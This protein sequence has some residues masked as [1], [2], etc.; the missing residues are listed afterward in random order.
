MKILTLDLGNEIKFYSIVEILL[1]RLG[2]LFLTIIYKNVKMIPMRL[3]SFFN[4][5]LEKN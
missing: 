1:F 3:S 5:I 2:D 4:I